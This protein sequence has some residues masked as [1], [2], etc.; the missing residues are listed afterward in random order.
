M[1]P[2]ALEFCCTAPAARFPF[3]LL[4]G[5]E[6]MFLIC[7][8]IFFGSVQEHTFGTLFGPKGP[9]G[10]IFEN[11]GGDRGPPK[12]AHGR[13]WASR[14]SVVEKKRSILELHVRFS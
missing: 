11:V 6:L 7:F 2:T 5:F 13:F 9:F 3:H 1:A 10:P 14:E 4:A 8:S 12:R